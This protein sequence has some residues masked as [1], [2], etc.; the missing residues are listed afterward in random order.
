MNKKVFVTGS[1]GLIG[2]QLVLRLLEEKFKVICYDLKSPKK[3]IY[4]KNIKFL[5][6]SILDK[7]KLKKSIGNSEVIIHLAAYL[8]VKNTEDNKLNC[9]DVNIE[10]TK[11]LLDI[12]RSKRI[13]KFIFAS[14]SEIYG[15]QK[16]F[17][18][19]ENAEAKFKNWKLQNVIFSFYF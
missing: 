2:S 1:S 9:L 3:K 4:N 18:I 7:K 15:E 14:S 6:G 17:P 16:K 5:N 10:G 19:N 13:K 8:G 11:N 12:A